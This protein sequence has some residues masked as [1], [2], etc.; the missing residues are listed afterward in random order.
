MPETNFLIKSY[1]FPLH[2][3]NDKVSKYCC[4]RCEIFYCSLDCYK[5]EKHAS[6]SESFYRDC[7]NNELASYQNDDESRNKMIEILKR[8]NADAGEEQFEE[9]M[10]NIDEVDSDDD[11]QVD[12]HERIKDINLNNA[13]DVWDALTEDERNDFEAL[14]N[15]GI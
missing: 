6:C 15:K 9:L 5:S 3:C 8:M 2:R 4:P 10:E 7:V 11:I 1:C 14:L 12:L 13:D